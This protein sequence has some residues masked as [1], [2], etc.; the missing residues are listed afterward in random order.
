MGVCEV[1]ARKGLIRAK[2]SVYKGRIV[3][4]SITGD[5][6]ISP[7]EAVFTAEERLTGL[8]ATEDAVRKVVSEAL[9]AVQIVGAT[10]DDFVDALLCAMR[11]ET[12]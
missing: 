4:A 5:F 12:T 8:E 11:G 10:L 7:E 2:V 3:E 6:L 1:K 9:S